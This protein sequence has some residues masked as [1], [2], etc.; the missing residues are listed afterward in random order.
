[1]AYYVTRENLREKISEWKRIIQPYN[2][3]QMKLEPKNSALLVIDMQKFFLNPESLTFT[4]G[5]LA[6]VENIRDLIRAYRSHSLPVIYTCHVHK[7]AQ[8]D[9]GMMSWWW[10]GIC[11]EG[12]E[13][14][15]IFEEIKPLPEEKIVF[16]HRYSAFYN[17]DLEIVLRCLGVK[18]LV[19]TGIM[20]NLC[21]ESTARDAYFRDYR[22][23]FLLDATGSVNEDLHV[24]GLKNI[25]FGFG[26][27]TDTSDI[28]ATVNKIKA[29][30]VKKES[31]LR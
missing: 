14:S 19:I 3:H 10:K 13:E 6:I 25:A 7:S 9:G 8:M 27:V 21:C 24:A 18:D 4:E 11:L 30:K 5:G 26:Y 12:T 29:D 28:L 23:F 22:V 31:V 17:T 16:K 15:K 20:T 2:T 1:M